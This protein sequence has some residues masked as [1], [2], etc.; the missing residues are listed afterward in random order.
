MEDASLKT[1][2]LTGDCRAVRRKE[3]ATPAPRPS[4]N[5]APDA[6]AALSSIVLARPKRARLSRSASA[7]G[8]DWRLRRIDRR[9]HRRR[10]ILRLRHV[11]RGRRRDVLLLRCKGGLGHGEQSDATA[12]R[13]QPAQTD[14]E[15]LRREV[16]QRVEGAGAACGVLTRDD[17]RSAASRDSDSA[18]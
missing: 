10:G 7:A 8:R 17:R 12:C 2:V 4:E 6:L 9:R 18:S 14:A 13:E 1:C 16:V 15:I 5:L 11:L 3:R